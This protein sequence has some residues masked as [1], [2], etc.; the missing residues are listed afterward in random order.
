MVARGG[1]NLTGKI[2]RKNGWRG[3]AWGSGK[4]SFALEGASKRS[5]YGA[6]VLHQEKFS[7]LY[8]LK[9]EDYV[10]VFLRTRGSRGEM[11]E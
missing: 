2:S 8:C 11:L 9:I 4:G 10:S 6:G 7:V 1:D 3:S 5:S